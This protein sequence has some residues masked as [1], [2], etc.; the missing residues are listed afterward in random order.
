MLNL[1]LSAAK[2]A[3]EGIDIGGISLIENYG[4]LVIPLTIKQKIGEDTKGNPILKELTYPVSC[5][6]NFQQCIA[7]KKYQRLVPN[8]AY[9]S[10]A[11]F[12]QTGDA[13]LTKNQK[14]KRIDPKGNRLVFDI[15]ARLVVWLNIQKMNLNDG[16]HDQ[17]SITAPTLLKI[18]E[19]LH[20]KNTEFIVPD[21]AY[22]NAKVE[23]IF[24]GQEVKDARRIF[25]KWS[26]DSEKIAAMY[27]WPFDWFSLKY[28]V[29][30]TV[31][32]NCVTAFTLG[33][34]EECIVATP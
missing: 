28:T 11:Y 30:L 19:T 16:A 13:V 27:L 2:T 17:C 1:A 26:Y 25:G 21:P 8:S 5:G 7:N 23:F 10:L 14:L 33:A 24:E 18:T 15:P 34:P 22:S 12:E 32:R 3:I 4:G 9:R 20:N 6:I 31:K 29:R